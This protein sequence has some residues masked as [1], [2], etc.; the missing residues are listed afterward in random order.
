MATVLKDPLEREMRALG[1]AAR[2]ASAE[3]ALAPR[4]AKDVA[5]LTG[6]AALRHGAES[7]LAANALTHAR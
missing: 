2:A 6:A 4:A 3:L 1:E 5:L 7:I